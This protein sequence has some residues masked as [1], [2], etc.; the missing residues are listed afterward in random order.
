MLKFDYFCSL[1]IEK[2]N[3][4][5]TTIKAPVEVVTEK[6]KSAQ[7]FCRRCNKNVAQNLFTSHLESSHPNNEDFQVKSKK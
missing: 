5:I 6:K 3:N 7:E 4:K 1:L 2:L